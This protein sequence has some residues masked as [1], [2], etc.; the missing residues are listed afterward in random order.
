MPL[1]E[2]FSVVD[3]PTD[4]DAS[5]E[6]LLVELERLL[7]NLRPHH[8]DPKRSKIL[9]GPQGVVIT[10]I[11]VLKPATTIEIEACGDEVVVSYGEEH[12]HLADYEASVDQVGPLATPGLVPKV[13]AFLRALLTG[14]IELE[15][16]HR[17]LLVTTRSYWINDRGERELFLTGGTFIPTLQWTRAPLVRTFDLVGS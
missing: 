13:I 9:P 15:V 7:V 4:I 14:R 8:L 6:H 3:L 11:H 17:L 12:V 5:N 1:P 2:F 16:S 10:L